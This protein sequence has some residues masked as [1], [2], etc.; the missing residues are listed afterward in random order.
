MIPPDPSYSSLPILSV[1]DMVGRTFLLDETSSGERPRAKVRRVVT[2]SGDDPPESTDDIEFICVAEDSKLESVLTYT[3][4]LDYLNRDIN[5]GHDM[6]SPDFKF[7]FTHIL[8]HETITPLHARWMKCR[9]NIL[10]EWSDGSRSWQPLNVLGADDPVTCA[11]YAMNNDLL[12]T[13][14]WKQF[15]CIAKREKVFKRLINQS[16]LKQFRRLPKFKYGMEIPRDYQDC[17]RLDKENGNTGWHDATMLKIKLLNSYAVFKKGA[18]ARYG[19]KRKLLNHPKDYQ[20]IAAMFVYDCKEDGRQRARFVARGDL[21]TVLL[22]SVYSGVVS[23]HDVRL[24]VFLAELNELELWGADISSAYLLADTKE[25]V[26]FI[27]DKAFGD[28]DG[29]IIYIVKA[30]YGLRTSGV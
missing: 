23:M 22:E 7:H 28:L 4:I 17:L 6:A 1:E 2:L 16:K 26:F 18:K 27:G 3:E 24:I 30:Q 11:Q 15:R 21:T 8:D 13:P 25:K 29:H 20:K 12:Q 9:T 10:V 19:P 5:M 14:G